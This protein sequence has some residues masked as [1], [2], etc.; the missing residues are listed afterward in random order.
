[1][2]EY[3]QWAPAHPIIYSAASDETIATGSQKIIAEFAH[4]YELL[5]RLRMMDAS[6]G[7]SLDDAVPYQF[8]INT[9][10]GELMARNTDNSGW[11]V[12]GKI[13]NNFGFDAAS[14]GAVPTSAGITSMNAGPDANK[15]LAAASKPGDW[16]IAVDQKKMYRMGDKDWELMLSLNAGNLIGYE[17]I[18]TTDDVSSTAAPNKIPK[19]NSTGGLDFDITGSAGKILGKSIDPTALA[20]GRVLVYRD[21]AG[22]FV[23]EAKGGGGSGSDIDDNNISTGTTYSSA[24]IVSAMA[25]KQDITGNLS[26][27]SCTYD[28][29][30][31]YKTIS[32]GKKTY[33][34]SRDSYGRLDT[35][36]DG[37]STVKASYNTNGQFLGMEAV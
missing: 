17:K 27:F 25:C 3:K 18:I 10:T 8:K 31:E 15:P 30:G 28:S 5:S 14:V 2:A 12:L 35:I 4:I 20:D 32:V 26:P 9:L 33:T 29:T 22:G 1:M 11:I 13:A 7:T 6:N 36:S 34:I 16:Y 37:S 19:A 21:T 24:K 23:F